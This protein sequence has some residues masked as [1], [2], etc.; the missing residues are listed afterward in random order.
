MSDTY[1]EIQARVF[2]VAMT[3]S[4]LQSNYESLKDRIQRSLDA[5]DRTMEEL[6]VLDTQLIDLFAFLKTYFPRDDSEKEI[7]NEEETN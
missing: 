1:T 2:A 4:Q 3:A 6:D 5:I 7:Q